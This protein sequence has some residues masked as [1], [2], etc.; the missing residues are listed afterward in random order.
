LGRVDGSLT[1]ALHGHHLLRTEGLIPYEGPI[2]HY[3]G[4]ELL[5]LLGTEGLTVVTTLA[6]PKRKELQVARVL[7]KTLLLHG[8]DYFLQGVQVLLA[9]SRHESRPRAGTGPRTG[10]RHAARS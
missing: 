7:L 8:V 5:E 6:G 9:L 4:V 10:S 1:D 2:C 3:L